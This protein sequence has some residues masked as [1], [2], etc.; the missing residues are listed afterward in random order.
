MHQCRSRTAIRAV[1]SKIKILFL[2]FP[3]FI[4]H[5]LFTTPVRNSSSRS[6]VSSHWSFKYG[7]LLFINFWYQGANLWRKMKH[8]ISTKSITQK[9]NNSLI[10][11]LDKGNEHNFLKQSTFLMDKRTLLPLKNI[12]F[13]SNFWYHNTMSEKKITNMWSRWNIWLIQKGFHP[14]L[15]QL[16]MHF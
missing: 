2:K 7:I 9:H 11:D 8:S 6:F 5:P 15:S 3:K 16:H 14:F 10:H 13:Q 12:M 1:I 4:G